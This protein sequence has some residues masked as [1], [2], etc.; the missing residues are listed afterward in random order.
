MENY[1]GDMKMNLNLLRAINEA[2]IVTLEKYGDS[3][4]LF[5]AQ[6]VGKILEDDHCFAEMQLDEIV[7]VL[8]ALGFK[9]DAAQMQAENLYQQYHT[10]KKKLSHIKK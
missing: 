2:K 10:N 6:V 1:Q 7:Q 3:D 5:R 9:A 4:N 8:V